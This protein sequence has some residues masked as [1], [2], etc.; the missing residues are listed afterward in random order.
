[1]GCC[2]LEL[3]VSSQAVELLWIE[4]LSSPAGSLTESGSDVVKR[5]PLCL[6]HF[7]VGEY[8]EQEQQ[9]S[10]DNEDIGTTQLL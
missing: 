2:C 1:M 9:H 6:W 5:S 3:R 8:E 4:F 7:E 10:E